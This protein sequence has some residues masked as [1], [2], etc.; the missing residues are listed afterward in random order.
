MADIENLVCNNCG[1]S[2]WEKILEKEKGKHG[3][4]RE[5]YRCNNCDKEGRKFTDGHN[6]HVMLSGAFRGN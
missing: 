5:V 1:E 4:V 3:T 6:G 2:N